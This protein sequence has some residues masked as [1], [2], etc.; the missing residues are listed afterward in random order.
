MALARQAISREPEPS[1]PIARPAAIRRAWGL[2]LLLAV[3]MAPV[4]IALA[5]T[6]AGHVFTGYVVIARDAFV[7]QALWRAGW[8]GAWL[9][10]PLYSGEPEPGILIYAW[11][12]WSGHGLGWLPGPLLYHGARMGAII[13][14]IAGIWKLT[15]V[16]YHPVLLRR[17]AF[18]LAVFGGGIG[19]LLGHAAHLGPIALRPTEV[20]VSG[21]SVA[22]AIAM[23]PHVP[24][25]A[26]LLC[27]VFVACLRFAR[28]GVRRRLVLGAVMALGLELI[29]P[30]LYALAVA[31]I[32]GWAVVRRP[33]HAATFLAV[34][35]AAGAPY[36]AYLG[37]AQH[38]DPSAFIGVGATAQVPFHFDV[39]DPIG[40]LLLSH[41]VASG[42]I[43]VALYTRRIRGDLALP[44]AWIVVM[45]GFMFLPGFR[46][47]VGRSYLVS[48]IPFGLLAAA[49]LLSLAR[50]L[51][52]GAGRRRTVMLA[53]AFSS[54]FGVFSL[55]QPYAI[56]L[57]RLDPNAEYERR[58]EAALLDWLQPRSNPADLVLTTY[59]DGIFVPAQS[60]ARVYAGHPDQTVDVGAKAGLAQAFFQ[61]WDMQQRDAFVVN[62]GI[63]YV[64]AGDARA[65][66]RL[67][68]D[69][70]LQVVAA[71]GGET[72]YRVKP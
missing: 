57:F 14:A 47:V 16:L 11:Y 7:Y 66:A 12:L 32:L 70:R 18:V 37:L 3:T 71:S 58:G 15:G 65:S 61:Q 56:A 26:A 19:L 30:Q 22:D 29:Y 28:D 35:I 13:V 62:N 31:T 42:L 69:A 1:R 45:T 21:T 50:R 53:L 52:P 68:Q 6:P 63:D 44:A 33:R 20:L 4:G 34:I 23:A 67:G 8:H 9:F 72:L 64:L 38:A 55:I 25:A 40:F 54:L 59:L 17:W 36:L 10:H 48:S 27:G 39:G 5:R 51:R 60:N 41:L 24:L 46:T 49:G 2:T 43:G